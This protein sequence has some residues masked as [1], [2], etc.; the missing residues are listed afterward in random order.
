M[1]SGL[2]EQG[3][4][5]KVIT[6]IRTS[7]QCHYLPH[8]PVITPAKNTTKLRIVYDAS[9]KAGRREKSLNECFHRGPVLLPDLCG[10][11]LHL[12]SSQLSYL[13]TLRKHFYRSTSGRWVDVT[14]FLWFKHFQTLKVVEDWNTC[15]FTDCQ[16]QLC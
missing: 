1:T 14:W 13:L 5:E 2:V 3:I 16:E 4:V 12:E 8:H 15:C 11:L 9:A 7:E 6:D 10:I